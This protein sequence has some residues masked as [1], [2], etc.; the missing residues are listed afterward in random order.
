MKDKLRKAVDQKKY[1][2]ESRGDIFNYGAE[3]QNTLK[4]QWNALSAKEVGVWDEDAKL[5]K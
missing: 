5:V 4:G 3:Y 2:A 1:D